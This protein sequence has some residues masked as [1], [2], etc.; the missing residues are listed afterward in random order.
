MNLGTSETENRITLLLDYTKDHLYEIDNRIKM[1][2]PKPIFYNPEYDQLT[3]RLRF[4]IYEKYTVERILTIG[5]NTIDYYMLA[6]DEYYLAKYVGEK[7]RAEI[8]YCSSL[9]DMFERQS[10]KKVRLKRKYQE[11]KRNT[12]VLPRKFKPR[13]GNQRMK[14]GEK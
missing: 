12:R 5:S 7:V 13:T 4:T 1:T 3:I 9:A 6:T 8:D 14:R 11:V 10:D 2:Y